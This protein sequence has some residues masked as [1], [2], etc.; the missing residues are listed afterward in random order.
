MV[1]LSAEISAGAEA[2]RQ[3]ASSLSSG[4]QDST[5]PPP[6]PQT[7]QL[8]APC[9]VACTMYD[10]LQQCLVRPFGA[11]GAPAL[12]HFLAPF[13]A[14]FPFDALGRDVILLSDPQARAVLDASDSAYRV[15]P[16]TASAWPVITGLPL[17][18]FPV[19]FAFDGELSAYSGARSMPA[20]SRVLSIHDGYTAGF[21][22]VVTNFRYAL[23]PIET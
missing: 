9:S 15:R 4:V 5:P 18:G 13:W 8:T 7:S 11:S 21:A 6:C 10:T 16:W 20:T 14:A 23:T 17:T 19:K 22:S 3:H 2:L 12:G 1:D